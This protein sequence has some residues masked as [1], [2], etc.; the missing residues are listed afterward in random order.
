[1]KFKSN[2]FIFLAVTNPDHDVF[3]IYSHEVGF[4]NKTKLPVIDALMSYKNLHLS[5]VDIFD[6]SEN[7]PLE[8]WMQGGILF[9]SSFFVT[10][11]SDILRFLSLWR[12]TGTYIDLDVI[13]KKRIDSIGTNF[14]CVQKDNF[15]NSA[16]I[17]LDMQG[18]RIAEKFFDHTIKSFDPTVWIGNGPGALTEIIHEMCNTSDTKQ[19]KRESCGG[20]SVLPT[21]ACYEIDYPEWEK[22]FDESSVDEVMCRTQNS[23]IIHFWNY[24]SS[25]GKLSTKSKA[26]YI[27]LAQEFCPR[28]LKAAGDFF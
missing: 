20:F 10:H 19:M 15:I 25:G 7:T 21:E 23:S 1:M 12:Y 6:Y 18:R 9:N 16:F 2:L 24:M 8:T 27:K 26:A 14:A 28:V 11:S 3:L 5:Y 13:V 22:F 17:N 4:F